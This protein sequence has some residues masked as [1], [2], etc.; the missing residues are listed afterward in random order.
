MEGAG[1]ANGDVPVGGV[2]A[3]VRER[4]QWPER[5]RVAGLPLTVRFENLGGSAY[6]RCVGARC[7]R[8][9]RCLL[10]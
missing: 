5:R 9:E 6:I 3:V 7:G 8:Q 4:A 2:G 1:R 10:A